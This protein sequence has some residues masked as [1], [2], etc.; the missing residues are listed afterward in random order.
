MNIN[1]DR[2][3]RIERAL[4]AWRAGKPGDPL[5]PFFIET[6]Y[7]GH[8]AGMNDMEQAWIAHDQAETAKQAVTK[9]HAHEYSTDNRA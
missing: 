6:W 1:H 5:E 2:I 7:A 8:Q 4:A 9:L 3:A